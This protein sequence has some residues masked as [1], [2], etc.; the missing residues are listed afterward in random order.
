MVKNWNRCPEKLWNL[1]PWRYPTFSWTKFWAACS[2]P[3]LNREVGLNDLQTSPPPCLILGFSKS[4]LEHKQEFQRACNAERNKK[5]TLC[6]DSNGTN[7]WYTS[8]LT[9]LEI[10]FH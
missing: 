6:C 7:L 8:N 4:T 2:R 9:R 3:A 5:L 10:M 1:H